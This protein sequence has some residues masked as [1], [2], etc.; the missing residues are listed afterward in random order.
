MLE[1]LSQLSDDKD[2]NESVLPGY[3]QD[4]Y[5]DSQ[6]PYADL[7]LWRIMTWRLFWRSIMTKDFWRSI[8][9]MK[10]LWTIISFTPA[11]AKDKI[12]NAT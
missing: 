10:T 9:D 11:D 1:T 4:P 6:D 8:Y 12:I 2:E 3:A 7:E 5:A